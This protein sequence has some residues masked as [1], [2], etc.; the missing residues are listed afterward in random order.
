MFAGEFISQGTQSFQV[1]PVVAADVIQG[2]DDHASRDQFGTVEQASI[3]EE[4]PLRVIQRQDA[5]RFTRIIRQ[6]F[7]GNAGFRAQHMLDAALVCCGIVINE[8]RQTGIYPQVEVGPGF[9]RLDNEIVVV[10]VIG[11]GVE[12]G[13]IK[14]FERKHGQVAP[15]NGQDAG[16]GTERSVQRLVQMPLPLP[17][18]DYLAVLEV[19]DG[20][21]MHA[22][23][24]TGWDVGGAHL[25]VARLDSAGT[26]CALEQFATPL[27]KGMETLAEPVARTLA[28]LPAGRSVH[29]LTMT[30]ELADCFPARRDG[31]LRLVDYLS[32]RLGADDPL[33]V[34]AGKR[35]LVKPAEVP[36]CHAE[37]AS[38]N[39]HGAAAYAAQCLGSGV[40]IDLGTT[41]TDIIPFHDKQVCVHGYTD[42]ERLRSGEL[43]YTGLT[44]TPVMAVVGRVPFARVWQG[45]AAE[46]F[47]NMADVYR[48][49]GELD[50]RFDVLPAADGGEKTRYHSLKRLARM[51]GADYDE[52]DAAAP[53]LE[54][55]RYIAEQQYETIERAFSGV[56]DR[57]GQPVANR[58]V[59]AGAGRFIIR[60]LARK[61]QCEVVDFEAL[62]P[63]A[64][65][66]LHAVNNCS[67]ALALAALT[68]EWCNAPG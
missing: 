8:R 66:E 53:L 54:S 34:Y 11:N 6:L 20:N 42:Q 21:N 19:D 1:R 60:K 41:T 35:G 3:A 16:F 44:R 56:M 15:D 36:G 61:H 63:L 10:A 5:V 50:E 22:E 17:G 49:T 4:L 39:W 51:L 14:R 37:I 30:G 58:I 47:A 31:V 68:R 55:A 43:V 65:G 12:I 62:L 28:A 32:E 23:N 27:W 25:K 2:H 40:L 57:V 45:V 67:T 24:Y 59:A 46:Y 18:C 52:E 13:D 48:I 38:A 29:A 64:Q 26:P 7:R 33:Y 9:Q